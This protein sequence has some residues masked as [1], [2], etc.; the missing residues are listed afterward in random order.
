MEHLSITERANR[1]AEYARSIAGDAPVETVYSGL[2][3]ETSGLESVPESRIRQA[4]NAANAALRGTEVSFDDLIAAEAIIHRTKRPSHLI[5]ND[6]FAPFDGEFRYLTDDGSVNSRLANAI[7]S[8]GRINLLER[9]TTYGGSGFIVGKNL[10][11]TNRHVAEIFTSGV[12]VKNVTIKPWDPGEVDFKREWGSDARRGF[13]LTKC[14]MIHPY[15]DMALFVADLPDDISP[16][17]M[18]TLPYSDLIRRDVVVIGYPAFDPE[19]NDAQVQQEIFD[20]KYNVK[21]IA[22]GRITPRKR[23]IRSSWL[24]NAVEALAHDSSTLGGNSG[25]AVID[26]LTGQVIALHFAGRYL[27]ENYGVPG[28][29]LSQ[30]PRVVDAGVA[31][32]NTPTGTNTALDQYWQRADPDSVEAG[33]QI[34]VPTRPA[35]QPRVSQPES[36][37]IEVPLRIS[38]SLGNVSQ[39]TSSAD[40][41]IAQPQESEDSSKIPSLGYDTSFLSERVETPRLSAAM[42]EDAFVVDGSYLIEYTHFSVCQSR[43]RRLPRFVAWNIDGGNL[44]SLSR[45]G[46]DFRLDD[47][48]PAE[49]Q[50]GNELYRNNDY[51]RGHVAR[52]ADLN[53]GSLPEAQDANRESFFFTNITPQHKRFNQSSFSGLWG[54]LENAIF[55]DIDVHDLRISV[56]AG[57]VFQE[58]DPAHRGVRI[59]RDF[60]KLIAFRDDSD[61]R[62]KVAAFILSQSEHVATE[63]LELEEFQLHQVS[64]SILQSRT[65]L[66]FSSLAAFDTMSGETEGI[67]PRGRRSIGSREQLLAWQSPELNI[68][69]T[70]PSISRGSS[71][72]FDINSLSVDGFSWSAAHATALCSQL[73]YE[74][75]LSVTHIATSKWGFQSVQV[76]E[77][78]DTQCFIANSPGA[79]VVS[80]RGSE[81]VPDWITNLSLYSKSRSYGSVHSGF[82]NAFDFVKSAVR[83]HLANSMTNN[84][85]LLFTGHSLGGA[86]A[87]IAG[88]EFHEEFGI[89]GIYTFGQ[90]RV[91]KAD[92]ASFVAS[93]FGQKFYRVVNDDDI[94]TRVP[95]GYEHVGTL[96]H[97]GPHGEIAESLL[98]GANTVSSE[99][100]AMSESEFRKLQQ[101]LD[102]AH[103]MART[104]PEL[105]EERAV[106]ATTEGLFPSFGDHKMDRYLAKIRRLAMQESSRPGPWLESAASPGFDPAVVGPNFPI[107]M[108]YRKIDSSLVFS[109]QLESTNVAN[110]SVR[111]AVA[112]N[113]G[114]SGSPVLIRLSDNYW[115]APEG[116]KV[117]SKIGTFATAHCTDSQLDTLRSDPRVLS[118]EASRDAGIPEVATS[119]PFIGAS[120]VHITP[121]EEAGEYSI[122]GVIDTGIDILHKAFLN[123]DG[124][125]RILGIWNQREVAQPGAKYKSP[126]ATFP[127]NFTQ[128]Y[129]VLY[130][131]EHIDE[132]IDDSSQVPFQLRD[133]GPQN[134][135]GHGTH[136]AS[137]A[138][139]RST[140]DFSGGVAPDAKLLAVIPN[141]ST[142]PADPPSLGYSNSHVDALSF[143]IA[144]SK[145]ATIGNG[146]PIAINVSLGMN[147]GAH[148]GLSTL[149]AAFDSAT[150]N[151]R[152]PGIV[153][154]KSAGNEG[155]SRGHA[156][157]QAF[158][159]TQTIA[160]ESD[161]AYRPRDYIELWYSWQHELE[162]SLVDPENRTS[163]TVSS[164]NPSASFDL[165][166]NFCTLLLTEYHPDNGH[167]R[168]QITIAPHTSSI[169]STNKDHGK[170]WRLK[171]TGLHI[172]GSDQDIHA[173]VER[174]NA[175]AVRFQTGDTNSMT[176]SIPGTAE[177]V[178]TVSASGSS[179]PL[180]L[181]DSSSRGLTRDNRAKPDICAPG[182]GIVAAASNS[183]D[184]SAIVAMTGTSMA[185]PH[186]AGAIALAMSLRVKEGKEQL[187]ANTIRALLKRHA[188]GLNGAHNSSFGFGG[189]NVQDFL[190]A[191]SDRP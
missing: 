145:A 191:V 186:V 91:G 106:A 132:F 35:T 28:H 92:F 172:G 2:S 58:D 128:D 81:S 46:I 171:V 98:E 13:A 24:Q 22:P 166:G 177:H 68:V 109:T 64:L 161:T 164:A 184:H 45:R 63:A 32:A 158:A 51:D 144:A 108:Q 36:V 110:E 113:R 155:N 141:M 4:E 107:A 50:A 39:A 126:K 149:E 29:E 23:P 114:P 93:R 163:M 14:I 179:L 84:R 33:T 99:S 42:R 138:A 16:I 61:D 147:A 74:P 88:A 85:K 182:T 86:L 90:P 3:S 136:V 82:S 120:L 118:V 139:G 20:G 119:L 47:R 115:T 150:N 162:F 190:S 79:I 151:G 152:V 127:D 26:V 7:P 100:P 72:G 124:S 142:N 121:L 15:W 188:T 181:T 94:V 34:S 104:D 31:F 70:A 77:A 131:K 169:Q 27:V 103:R 49:F 189:L 135:P 66:D 40:S 41:T 44:K 60:W 160:W 89:S 146:L 11:M 96:F 17:Q 176:I 25:S 37:T 111:S 1:L 53:W 153:V 159:G 76:I 71:V 183:N 133:P 12:G 167:H 54:E 129:G 69:D 112:G 105:S 154:I 140:G 101:R 48:V 174:D 185:A 30:D 21:R 143:L 57:P 187:N 117:H 168:L 59:P 134:G 87:T 55:E 175:R 178:V 65:G 6:S 62:F 9:P 122:V 67:M 83:A 116:I 148:D 18:C 156:Q 173:W 170:F 10:V 78:G 5:Q 19:R 97:L 43:S 80:F 95:P 157:I 52:R 130:T 180:T 38:V 165:G 137:I 102:V 73:A 8:V 125:T 56:L 123:G 75:P